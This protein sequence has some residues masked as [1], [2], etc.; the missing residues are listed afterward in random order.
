[1]ACN[2]YVLSMPHPCL[3]F[4]SM[5]HTNFLWLISKYEKSV[6]WTFWIEA[7][8]DMMVWVKTCI[9]TTVWCLQYTSSKLDNGATNS[10]NTVTKQVRWNVY[11]DVII[12]NSN[13]QTC[14][15]TYTV[16]PNQQIYT[17]VLNKLLFQTL[18]TK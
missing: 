14:Y 4:L 10:D 15:H 11:W 1:M 8:N 6:T 13:N 12:Y 3:D 18:F 16:M 17:V 2:S 7:T 9:R 5:W